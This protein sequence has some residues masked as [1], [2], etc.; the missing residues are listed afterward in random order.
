MAIG[1]AVRDF[2]AGE[3]TG[4]SPERSGSMKD[5]EHGKGKS[6]MGRV[7]V[8]DG[9]ATKKHGGSAYKTKGKKG[10]MSY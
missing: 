10:G 8:R 3:E 1:D 5:R 6:G 2:L 9:R 4:D 7:R